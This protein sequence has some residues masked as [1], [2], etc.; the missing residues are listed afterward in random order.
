MRR[1]GREFVIQQK[2]KLCEIY[3]A[4]S[5]VDNLTERPINR[6]SGG[7]AGAG[8]GNTKREDKD[9]KQERREEM[10]RHRTLK[11]S[12]KVKN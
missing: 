11:T 3:T 1:D 7:D 6:K 8:T 4:F 9:V 10:H 12:G 5:Q 2:L